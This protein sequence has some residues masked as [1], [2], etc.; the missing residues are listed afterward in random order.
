GLNLLQP[1]LSHRLLAL[2]QKSAKP[3]NDNSPPIHR[4]VWDLEK[5]VVRATDGWGQMLQIHRFVQSSAHGLST[6]LPLLPALKRWAIGIQS[7][8]R[9]KRNTFA[10]KQELPHFRVTYRRSWPC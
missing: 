3:T 5:D 7:A 9:T 8:S 2:L 4:W 10:A 6:A 1:A